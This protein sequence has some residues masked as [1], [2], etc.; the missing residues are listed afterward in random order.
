MWNPCELKVTMRGDRL[1]RGKRFF[2]EA[3]SAR[4]LLS[5]AAASKMRSS[6]PRK[7][8]II[9]GH[10]TPFIGKGHPDFIHKVFDLFFFFLRRKLI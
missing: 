5:A 4:N 1:A 9:G 2:L 10:V 6:L 3:Q 8:Y 7:T